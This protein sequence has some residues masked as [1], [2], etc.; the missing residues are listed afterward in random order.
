[1]KTILYEDSFKPSGRGRVVTVDRRTHW[2]PDLGE[3]VL[4]DN[5]PHM[6]V[7]LE[8]FTQA[9]FPCRAGNNVGIMVSPRS[10]EAVAILEETK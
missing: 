10:P 1:M 4:V 9:M 5:K 2:I 3:L 6:V 8:Q 7:G